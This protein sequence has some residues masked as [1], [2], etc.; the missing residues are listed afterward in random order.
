MDRL[1]S[2]S[3]L[4]FLNF[5]KLL[6]VSGHFFFCCDRQVLEKYIPEL[7]KVLVYEVFVVE[8]LELNSFFILSSLSKTVLILFIP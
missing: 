2:F 4:R 3:F 7:L 6:F 8:I 1:K 5:F